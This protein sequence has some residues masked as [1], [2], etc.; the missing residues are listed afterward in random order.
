MANHSFAKFMLR[1][2]GLYNA[3]KT[4]YAHY[5]SNP[6]TQLIRRQLDNTDLSNQQ[7]EQ[8]S[9]MNQYRLMARL[10]PEQLPDMIDTGFKVYSQF[11]EDGILLYIF[12][13]I[14]FSNRKVIDICCGNGRDSNTANLII[15]HA[16]Y[17]L[18][19]DGNQQNIDEANEFYRTNTSTLIM[20]PL[21]RCVWIT[22]DNINQLIETE[23]WRGDIDL[24]S[25][26]I[27]GIDYY[28]WDALTAVSPRVFICE[29]HNIVPDDMAITIPYKEDF[30]YKSKDNYHEEFRSVSPLAMIR[31]SK[32]K[33]YRLVG[34]HKYGFNLIFLRNDVG[35]DYFPEVELSSIS[36]NPYTILGK[37]TRWPLVKNAPWV[38]V[39]Q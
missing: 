37:K 9:L 1:R 24:L 15:N 28:V 18:L 10:L 34:S 23:D 38:K 7:M 2:L 39:E 4:V 31:L 36:N 22:K 33:G 12:S 6:E 8:V 29:T 3:A 11:D 27:D 14:G 19:F 32:R 21:G 25:L 16:C 30:Y 5:K 17:G 26:D 35:N 20:P 13:L